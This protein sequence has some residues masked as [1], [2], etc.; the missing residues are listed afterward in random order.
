MKW[1][2][3]PD[4]AACCP[5]KKGAVEDAE[6]V[7]LYLHSKI[8]SP[9]TIPFERTKLTGEKLGRPISN[10]CGNADGVSV[11]RTIGLSDVELSLRAI[12]QAERQPNRVSTGA[13]IAPVASLRGIRSEGND[14]EQVVFVYDDPLSD[15]DAHAVIRLRQGF[16]RPEFIDIRRRIIDAFSRRVA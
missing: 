7:A 14:T 3:R 13:K 5:G 1:T 4:S 2:D 8:D 9:D 12:T 6:Q 15:N 11:D 10:D 16:G